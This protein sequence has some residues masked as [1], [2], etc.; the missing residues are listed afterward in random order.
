MPFYTG[1]LVLLLLLGEALDWKPARPD[2]A[3]SFPQDH[4]AR[5]G[6]RTEW[7]YFTGHLETRE[8]VPRR[9]GYQFTFF[10]V[11]LQPSLPPLDSTWT[12]RDVIMGHAAVTDLKGKRHLFS[13]IL[14]RAMPLLGE[15]GDGSGSLIAWSRAPAGSS[16]RW[17]LHWNG[18]GFDLA[19]SDES[20]DFSFRLT[21]HGTMG[22]IFQ[23]PNG[24]SIKGGADGAA[25]QY[26]SFTRMATRGRVSVGSDELEVEGVSWMDKEFGSQQLGARQ[27]G[28]DWFS[29]QLADGR[30]LM[31]YVLRDL[32]NQV[33]FAHGT[34]ISEDG[35][36]R[37]LEADEWSVRSSAAWTSP[38]TGARYPAGWRVR[39]PGE[40][41]EMVVTPEVPDS[42]NVSRLLPGLAYWEGPVRV[43]T[44]RGVRLGQ[45]YVELTGYAERSRPAL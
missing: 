2:Y 37:Y 20:Q 26:Y 7:W 22:P 45:G 41:L 10:R 44:S 15:F 28:W 39:V 43:E 21:T 31:L 4:W 12:A 14:Y 23:G 35:R 11:G 5:T 25:S 19:A 40:S 34:L 6:Y 18:E 30:D 13:E 33:D 24:Y 1:A 9:F 8:E 42:E 16:G 36:T 29:L 17:S 38:H 3:W 27:V 32:D